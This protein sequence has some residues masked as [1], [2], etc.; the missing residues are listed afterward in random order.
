VVA[1]I[2]FIVLV[3]MLEEVAND[4]AL[5][6]I[7]FAVDVA[8]IPFIVELHVN[9]FAV[10]AT[11]NRLLLMIVLV[12][13]IP[14]V[15]LVRIFAA[16]ERVFEVTAVVV[17]IIPFTVEVITFP[18]VVA[19]FVTT[20]PRSEVVAI[21]PFIFVVKRAVAVANDDVLLVIIVLVADTPLTVVV[22]TFPEVDVVSE[23]MKF[24]T[25]EVMPFI[26]EVNEL[27]GVGEFG[28]NCG[29]PDKI[30]QSPSLMECCITKRS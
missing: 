21:T 20:M 10:V 5:V 7:T 18:E 13:E 11:V 2:P 24:T 28:L 4:S 8:K 27:V 15:L 17:A 1:L 14:F 29:V 22:S 3:R 23:F 6:L 30:T 12:A 9:A 19:V 25:A 16:E 26:V